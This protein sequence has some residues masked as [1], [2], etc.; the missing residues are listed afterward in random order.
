M[1]LTNDSEYFFKKLQK[2][3]L[4][5]VSFRFLEL[6]CQLEQVFSAAVLIQNHVASFVVLEYFQLEELAKDIQA[7]LVDI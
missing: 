7:T 3:A 2:L 6:L 1:K 4:L 5:M